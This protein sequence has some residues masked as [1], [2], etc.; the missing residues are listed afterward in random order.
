MLTQPNAALHPGLWHLCIADTMIK[1]LT[2]G[3]KALEGPWTP[4]KE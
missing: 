3:A 4:P 2:E 1:Q